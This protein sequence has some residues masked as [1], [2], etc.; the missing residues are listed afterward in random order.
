M[1]S[2]RPSV[3]PG[4]NVSDPKRTWPLTI[5][6]VMSFIVG[7]TITIAIPV[8]LVLALFV[9]P[10]WKF[11]VAALIALLFN[12]VASRWENAVRDELVYED[13]RASKHKGKGDSG[14]PVDHE[15][16]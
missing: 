9:E 13:E 8:F 2:L 16:G 11:L 7:W 12:S 15:A 10:A 14:R 5:E 3:S 4:P 6:W 1:R